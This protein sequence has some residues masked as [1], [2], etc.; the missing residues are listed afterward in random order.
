MI[1][2]RKVSARKEILMSTGEHIQERNRM[3]VISVDPVTLERENFF[4]I[5]VAFI[6][7]KDRFSAH[8]V[9]RTSSGEIF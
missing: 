3:F 5:S 4:S 9:P 2:V 6:H 1:S 8:I 7:T